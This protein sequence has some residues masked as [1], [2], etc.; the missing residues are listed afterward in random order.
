MSEA[1]ELQL[2]ETE[3]LEEVAILDDASAEMMLGRIRAA[4]EQYEKMEAWYAFQLGKAKAIR[5]RTVEWA[6]RSLQGYFD[7]VPTKN[8]K[9]QRS[10]EL[11]SGKLT[12]KAQQPEYERDDETLVTWLK[13]NGLSEMIK[14]KETANW[15][16]LKKTLRESPDGT[17]MM[18]TDGEIVPGI[19]VTQRD[20]KFTVTLK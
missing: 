13:E 2:E 15:S 6:E 19:K 10:Y 16:E 3:E 11:P 12:L 14:I 20:P 8:A 4:N 18:T 7:M 17:T 9:T 1:K 5:D